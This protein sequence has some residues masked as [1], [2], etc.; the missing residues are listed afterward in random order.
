MIRSGRTAMKRTQLHVSRIVPGRPGFTSL[1]FMVAMVVLG[2]ALAGVFPLMVVSSRGIESLELRYTAEGNKNGNWFSPIF[3]RDLTT[4]GI[5][6]RDDY[7]V[8]YVVPSAD[9]WAG[10][11]GAAATFSRTRPPLASSTRIID[12]GDPGYASSGSWASLADAGAFRG[13]YHRHDLQSPATDTAV[14]TFSNVAS[15]HYYVLA[16]WRAA[17]DQATDASYAVYNGDA[18]PSPVTVSVDQTVAPA[19][20][21]YG[22]WKLLTTRNFTSADKRVKVALRSNTDKAV[23][24]DGVRIVP[25]STILS[26]NKSF[27]TEEVTLHA[28]IGPSP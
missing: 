24:A 27:N 28:K 11:L 22:G 25:I 14:W 15:G 26:V 2:V 13:G 19:S 4:T 12:D 18:D 17:S 7:G 10:K 5:I 8:W 16:T 21:V 20:N 1:E 3:R 6:P 9:S 23:A